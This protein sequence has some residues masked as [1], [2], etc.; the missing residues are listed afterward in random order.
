MATLE[1]AIEIATQAHKV[2]VDKNGEP[3][4]THILRVM[5]AGRTMNEKIAGVL[6]DLVEDT[7]W[8]FSDLEGEGFSAEVIDAVKCLAKEENEDYNHFLHRVKKNALA[9]KVK[10]N[11]LIDNMDIKR[12]N[13]VTAKDVARLN[14]Y[15]NA[16]RELINL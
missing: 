13:E 3:Y 12:M 5:N 4:V 10:I 16:Y 8:T 6:H 14:K 15:L 11:D 9:I 1:R 7:Q 2:Q